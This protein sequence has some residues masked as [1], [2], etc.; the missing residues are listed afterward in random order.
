[1][2]L[3]LAVIAGLTAGLFRARINKEAYQAPDLQQGW[4]VY[5]AVIPQLLT[6]HLSLTALAIPDWI[7]PSILVGSQA[8]L[9]YFAWINRH[10][11]GFPALGLGLVLNLVVIAAN[12]GLMPISTRTIQELLPEIPLSS[13]SIGGRPG[14]SKNILL[15]ADQIKLIWLADRFL[16][17]S[18]FPWPRAFSLGDVLISIG[19]FRLLWQPASNSLINFKDPRLKKDPFSMNSDQRGNE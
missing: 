5:A 10:Q 18:W 15:Q 7:A 9:V 12:G 17:P 3:L 4:L 14:H 13:W 16:V 6:F 1:M 2:I 11:P 19:A 8:C